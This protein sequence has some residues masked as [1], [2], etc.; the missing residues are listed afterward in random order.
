VN[1]IFPLCRK[2]S[3]PVVAN[4]FAH[5]PPMASKITPTNPCSLAHVNTERPDYP[6]FLGARFPRRPGPPHYLA[7]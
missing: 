2:I 4:V 7:F 1:V 3:K 6:L 5:E